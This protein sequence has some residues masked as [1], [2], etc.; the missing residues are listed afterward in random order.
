MLTSALNYAR[1]Q[2]E[3]S[4]DHTGSM[5]IQTLEEKMKVIGIQATVLGEMKQKS[6]VEDADPP[7]DME[8]KGELTEHLQYSLVSLNDVRRCVKPKTLI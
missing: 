4:Q 7:F 5:L 8:R 3:P 1:S 6:A 2:T